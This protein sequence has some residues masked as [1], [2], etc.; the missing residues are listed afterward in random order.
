MRH[1]II[2]M[3]AAPSAPL[4]LH[5]CSHLLC[6]WQRPAVFAGEEENATELQSKKIYVHLA[7]QNSPSL[8]LC[9]QLPGGVRVPRQRGYREAV[10][11]QGET[12]GR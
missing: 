8:S 10:K 2:E 12:Y 6:T 11:E 1:F 4:L 3:M 7:K 9:L 5:L